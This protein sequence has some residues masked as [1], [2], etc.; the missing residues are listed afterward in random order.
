[1]MRAARQSGFSL[2]ELMIALTIGMFLLAGMMTVYINGSKSQRQ[3]Q[4]SAGQIENGRYAMDTLTQSI[5]LAGYYGEYASIA[6]AGGLP[7]P[8]AT[9]AATLTAALSYPVEGFT[10]AQAT[11]GIPTAYP[12]LSATTCGTALLPQA[13]LMPG[14]DILVV[15]YADTATLAV[16]GTAVSNEVYL[17]ADAL[18]AQ[19]QLGNGAATTAT[20]N[21]SGGTATIQDNLLNAAPINQYH[22]RIYFV[23]PCSVPAGGGTVCTGAGDDQG[24]PIPTLKYLDLDTTAAGGFDTISVSE[25]IQALKLEY[26]IDDVPAQKNAQ[27]GQ[28][29]DGVPD[30]YV[31]SSTASTPVATDFPNAVTVKV[32]LIARDR[33]PATGFT[34]NVK[35]YAV[36]TS[37]TYNGTGLTY[38]PYNDAYHRHAYQSEVRLENLASRREIPQ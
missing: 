22:T 34:D 33:D 14:S 23:A 24:N 37:A 19:I 30:Y 20:S 2:I 13:N 12:D 32:F 29:G 11:S 38:G 6:T 26:G 10:A 31:P 5:H 21:A 16:G 8:C 17:Q 28:I 4:E 1:M 9:D 18:Q 27:T 3:L 36:A 35:T 15:R 7:D 25:G